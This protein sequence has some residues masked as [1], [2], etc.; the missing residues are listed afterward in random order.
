[1][2]KNREYVEG[3]LARRGRVAKGLPRR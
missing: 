2:R 3:R 1:L